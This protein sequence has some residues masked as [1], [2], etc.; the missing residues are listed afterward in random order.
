MTR[1][2]FVW[3]LGSDYGHL[4][5]LLPVAVALRER[6]H[7]VDFVV[8]DLMGAEKLIAPLGMRVFQAPL[9]LRKVTSC[10]LPDGAPSTYGYVGNPSDLDGN[11]IT[12]PVAVALD[13]L[14]RFHR[15]EEAV[16]RQWL[17]PAWH[18]HFPNWC[19]AQQAQTRP[20]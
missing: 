6:G 7:G 15:D 11:L 19:A 10:R 12:P 17:P 9:W 4:A 8:R 18:A 20:G 5:R 13:W 16:M 14:A 1:F 2:L 3:E